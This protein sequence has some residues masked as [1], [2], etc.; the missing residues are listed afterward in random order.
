MKI[1]NKNRQEK[2]ITLIALVVTIIVLLI[3]AGVA[4]VTLTGEN[5]LLS[6][7]SAA[8]ESTA[9]SALEEE[10]KLAL[11]EKK[12]NNMIGDNTSDLGYYLSKI[13]GATIEQLA[14]D[15]WYVTRGKAEVTVYDS[16]DITTGKIDIWDGVSQE[17]PQFQESNWYIYNSAQMKF[18]ADFVNNANTL[19]DEQKTLVAE[20]GYNESDITITEDTIVYLMSDLDLGARQTNGTLTSGT[21]WTPIGKTSELTFIGTFEGNNHNILGVYIDQ[22]ENFA[23]IFGTS[24]TIMNLTIKNSYIKGASYSAGIVGG[25]GTGTVE[26]CHNINTTVILREGAY[27]CVGGVVG[28]SGSSMTVSNCSNSGTIIGDGVNTTGYSRVGGV[29]GQASSSSTVN[30]CSNTGTITGQGIN[31]GGVI[32]QAGNSSTVSNCSNTGTVTGQEHQVGGVVGGLNTSGTVSNCNNTG[33]VSGQGYHVGGIAGYSGA[34]STVS[35]CSNSGEIT[36][37]GNC[38]GGIVGCAASIITGC[39][40]IGNV[41]GTTEGVGGIVGN[42]MTKLAQDISLCYNSGIVTGEGEVGGI[43][44][45]LGAQGYSGR[46]TKCYN[47][48]KIIYKGKDTEYG[49]IVGCMASDASVTKCYY[50][51]NIGVTQ[52]VGAINTGGDLVTQNMGAQSTDVDL[53]TYEEFKNWIEQQ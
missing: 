17:V 11:Q 26:N 35:N 18:F 21:E 51:S 14:N 13:G 36:G 45:Y 34:S 46:E 5:G 38:T 32:G 31:V 27:T 20:E 44:G 16:G 12:T 37:G 49:G 41:T 52:G 23:G 25:L 15:A 4:I 30:D 47:K 22:T 19:T 53:K 40:N 24:N 43:S 29:I 50:L 8:T 28:K 3:L 2:G 33:V 48:G 7:A 1:I 10:V 39:Y 9:Q 42:C 6:K